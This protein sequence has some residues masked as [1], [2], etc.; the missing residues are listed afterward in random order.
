M[1]LESKNNNQ[2]ILNNEVP[3][4]KC[5]KFI[6]LKCLLITTFSELRDTQKYHGWSQGIEMIHLC[7]NSSYDSIVNSDH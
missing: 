5:N 6:N 2:N 7:L 1:T 3:Y 4:F